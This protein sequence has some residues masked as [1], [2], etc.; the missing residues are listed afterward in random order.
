MGASDYIVGNAPQAASYAA[1]LAGFAFGQAIAGLPGDYM[2]G[3]EAGRTI[4][5]QDAFKNGMPI[6]RDANGNPVLDAN[7]NPVPDTKAI[8]DT[9]FKY[10]GLDF[11]TQLFP[12]LGGQATSQR[13]GEVDSGIL[14][15]GGSSPSYPRAE[16]KSGA[17]P[18][19]IGGIR[20]P[21]P[22]LSSAGIDN[23]GTP[24]PGN[25]GVTGSMP[26]RQP[27][28]SSAG[29]DNGGDQ[30]FLGNVATRVFGERDISK[31][32]SRYAAALGIKESDPLTPEQE[33]RAEVM[34]RRTA[35]AMPSRNASPS[36]DI[37]PPSGTTSAAERN[38][39]GPGGNAAAPF[40][41]SGASGAP[42]PQAGPSQSGAP[43]PQGG[44]PQ[45]SV[46]SGIQGPA[47]ENPAVLRAVAAVLPAWGRP[48]GISQLR[49]RPQRR[50]PVDARQRRRGGEVPQR[51][52]TG[53]PASRESQKLRR[54]PRSGS[55]RGKVGGRANRRHEG[56]AGRS[57]AGRN[58]GVL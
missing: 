42:G 35:Q 7:G 47:E 28:F 46:T 23:G 9:G 20:P 29:T 48:A 17:G 4:A 21:Q 53:G 22:Q 40:T 19:N 26:A 11:A 6:Q 44:P 13:Q 57:T 39:N 43:R 58:A 15:C 3:R 8:I 16:N 1:P 51:R 38:Q 52:R 5:K 55:R 36:E 50:D 31:L 27:A 2:K 25:V 33:Q 56:M 24:S 34:M 18:G 30:T 41:A 12:Y 14:G 37:S 54:D 49:P 32:L 10:G 45:A